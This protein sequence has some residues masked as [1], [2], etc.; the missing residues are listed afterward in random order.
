MR[1]LEF[2]AVAEFDVCGPKELTADVAG[3]R[4][5]R[6]AASASLWS[7][8]VSPI[9][10]VRSSKSIAA[11]IELISTFDN[12]TC[13]VIHTLYGLLAAY[14]IRHLKCSV[15]EFFVGRS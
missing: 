10:W 7:S 11:C 15:H 3:R 8:V 2:A 1:V 6:N 12:I 5:S 9:T 14:I 4:R 13:L